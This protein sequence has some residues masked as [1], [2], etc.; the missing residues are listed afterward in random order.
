VLTSL[1][2]DLT[3][4]TAKRITLHDSTTQ[5]SMARIPPV[6]L[7]QAALQSPLLLAV[8]AGM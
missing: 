1:K 5:H 4:S 6:R 2:L 7:S 8:V 3:I